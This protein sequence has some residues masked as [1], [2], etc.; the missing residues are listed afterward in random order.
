MMQKILTGLIIVISLILIYN[1]FLKPPSFDAGEKA[2]EIEAT[3]IDGTP[4]SLSGL[5]GKYVLLDFWG[6]WCAPC[7]KEI[8][9]LKTLYNDFHGKSFKNADDF[10]IVSIALEKSDRYT[11]QLIEQEGLIWPYHIIEESR[12]VM[13]SSLAQ[14]YDVKELPTKFLINPEGQLMGTDLPIDEIRRILKERSE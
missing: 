9:A 3:L 14:I 8:P 13:M 2:P 5:E 6:S 10:E 4:F 11:R 7:R 1:F 12:I